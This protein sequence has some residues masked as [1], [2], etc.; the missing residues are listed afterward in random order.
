M[1]ERLSNIFM[2]P[3]RR[4][5]GLPEAHYNLGFMY[6]N[7]MGTDKNYTAAKEQFTKAISK[8]ASRRLIMA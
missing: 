6:M 8:E 2:K 7:G 3:Q 1:R 4:G 5:G